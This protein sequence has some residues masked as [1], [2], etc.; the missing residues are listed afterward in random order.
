MPKELLDRT[1]ITTMQ[2][3]ITKHWSRPHYCLES[4]SWDYNRYKFWIRK[5]KPSLYVEKALKAITNIS[6]PFWR[7][8]VRRL[9]S[10]KVCEVEVVCRNGNCRPIFH[11]L[12]TNNTVATAWRRS[13]IGDIHSIVLLENINHK[14]FKLKIYQTISNHIK[15]SQPC[16]KNALQYQ[17][18]RKPT[19]S[20]PVAK[21][22]KEAGTF[23]SACTPTR[24]SLGRGRVAYDVTSTSTRGARMGCTVGVASMSRRI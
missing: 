19:I 11:R 2:L 12:D 24:R 10:F 1:K 21:S 15:G 8:H 7:L 3:Q 13:G 5:T 22:S 17:Q 4:E 14:R 20:R 16:R 9:S 18:E 6:I 23:S